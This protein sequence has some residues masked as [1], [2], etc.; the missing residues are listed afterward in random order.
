[1]IL[2]INHVLQEVKSLSLVMQKQS[3]R[4]RSVKANKWVDTF[5]KLTLKER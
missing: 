2:K 3:R 5:V 4:Q 1:M